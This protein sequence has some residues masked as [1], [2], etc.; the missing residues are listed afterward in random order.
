MRSPECLAAREALEQLLGD[1]QTREQTHAAKL[2]SAR[3]KVALACL[4]R[5]ADDRPGSPV[6]QAP[7]AVAPPVID[8]TPPRA[9]LPAPAPA[10]PLL[11]IPRPAA[12]T[13]CDAAGCWDS[14][15]RRLNNLG[16]VLM[17]PRGPCIVQGSLV[18]CP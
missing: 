6:L 18:N 11:S 14:E 1:P 4:G 13:A 3:K 2:A 9:P 7:Q 10:P 17:G 16:P 15:G 12:I 5:A 8:V